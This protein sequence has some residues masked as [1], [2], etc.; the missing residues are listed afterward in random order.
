MLQAHGE[1]HGKEGS[2]TATHQGP[3]CN[4]FTLQPVEEPHQSREEGH[5]ETGARGKPLLEQAPGRSC[6]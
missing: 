2:P 1:D 5:E 6:G 3:W 4:T